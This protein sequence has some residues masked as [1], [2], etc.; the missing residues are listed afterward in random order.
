[1][2]FSL[3]L[4]GLTVTANVNPS[5]KM[6]GLAWEVNVNHLFADVEYDLCPQDV[7]IVEKIYLLNSIFGVT[8]AATMLDGSLY[9][10]KTWKPFWETKANNV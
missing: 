4:A 7:A 5:L 6:P 8:L 10:F 3:V 9:Y 2:V 1:M